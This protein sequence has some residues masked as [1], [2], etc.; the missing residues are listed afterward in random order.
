[1]GQEDEVRLAYRL[2]RS[3]PESDHFMMDDQ[4]SLLYKMLFDTLENMG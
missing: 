3:K 2:R 4:P 1:M